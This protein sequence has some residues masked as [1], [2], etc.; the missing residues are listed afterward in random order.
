MS[1][2]DKKLETGFD[3]SQMKYIPCAQCKGF[4]FAVTK[5]KKIVSCAKCQ[6]KPS[7]FAW[8]DGDIL[9]WSKKINALSILE[10]KIER[11]VRGFIDGLLILLVA[12]GVV[13]LFWE[14][15]QIFRADSSY[16]D[17]LLKQKPGMLVFWV[18]ILGAMY[19]YFRMEQETTRHFK[20]RKRDF[21]SRLKIPPHELSFRQVNE[22]DKK[23]LTDI[24]KYYSND[25]LRAL[26]K[27]WLMANQLKH[28]YVKPIHILASILPY[29]KA[30][31]IMGRLGID[32][33]QMIGK[34][35]R[36]LAAQEKRQ[37]G[38]AK[39]FISWQKV[40]FEAYQEA[41]DARREK[42]D[43][44]E[45]LIAVMKLSGIS[46]D[47]LYDLKISL[48]KIRNV[49]D[50]IYTIKRLQQQWS[51]WKS[52]ASFKPKGVMNRAMT[53]RPTPLLDSLSKDLTLHATMG[54]FFPLINR[55]KEMEET[56]RVLKERIG[57][58][59]LVGDPGVGKTTII[60]GVAERMS[61][62]EVPKG[63]QD[64][65]LIGL[66]VGALVAGAGSGEVEARV[67]QMIKEIIQAGNVVLVIEDIHNLVG[68]ST[69]GSAEDASSILANALSEGS[70]RVIG[71]TTQAG[72]AKYIENNEAFL[73][74]F[75]KVDIKEP[76]VNGCIRVL[77]AK[78]GGMEYR[79]DVF[80]SYNAIEAAVKLSDRYI[81]DRY[82]PA[83]AIDILEEATIYTKET[84]GKK[85]TVTREDVAQIISEK[86]EIKVSEITTEESERLLKLEEEMHKRM[87]DQN[88]AVSAVANALRRAR[89][90]LRDIERPI[91]NFLFLGPTGVGKTELAKTV[92]EVYFGNEKN[93]VRLDM[94]EYQEK[95]S[96]YRLIGAPQGI[97]SAEAQTGYLTEAVRQKP[98]SL[99]L[100][101]ELEKAHPD[102]LNVFLQV[103]DDGRA[104]DGLGHTIDFTNSIIIA[105]SNAGTPVIQ[106]GIRNNESLEL[107]KRRLL[108][109]ELKKYF[110]PEFINRFD[111]VIVFKPLSTQDIIEI[112]RL[113]LEKVAAKLKQKGISFKVTSDAI[114]ELAQE[115][116][117]PE[118]GAR[119]MRRLIQD[120]VDNALAEHLL[121]G[122]ISRRDVAV[123]EKDGTIRI[124]KAKE[125]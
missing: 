68:A 12:T 37:K 57:N 28:K 89:E 125:L 123:L 61:S 9:F 23:K 20:I 96:I 76:D 119:P 67:L 92:A 63:L 71:T 3:Q 74:R 95:S 22:M 81:H 58:V 24:A 47:I 109:K 6:K 15:W 104:T 84:K 41:F 36:A 5:E 113:M 38:Q 90:E 62:E 17:L 98:F 40:L 13:F 29:N 25:A 79:H 66:N 11:F 33:K 21:I 19:A 10:N 53:A 82:L 101:D 107:I 97:G 105:T 124:E 78:S 30:A 120:K 56:F 4:G 60:E 93:M 102:I 77:E 50:W 16:L 72:Y 106:E 100:L 26:E 46:R 87:I 7:L 49:T 34:V 88:E 73:R 18:A 43:V 55:E 80:M 51:K 114:I 75:Q 121:K 118:F 83:K 54:A 115:G 42:V 85:A 14:I 48:D 35:S 110:R 64:K 8:L 112:T 44:A 69:S 94:S 27:S 32:S 116:Y 111:G 122:Q 70:F 1:R 31:I 103:M 39:L 117:D 108:E 2:T 45:L 65:R 52:K 86:T 91:A 99:I 59:L